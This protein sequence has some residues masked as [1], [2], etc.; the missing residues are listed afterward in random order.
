[1]RF[2][3]RQL[4]REFSRE[5]HIVGI[6]K[7]N[8]LPRRQ[9]NASIASGG[10]SLIGLAD[11]E[12]PNETSCDFCRAICRTIVDYDDLK[13]GPI[14]GEHRADRLLKESFAVEYGNYARDHSGA[15]A[16]PLSGRA[17]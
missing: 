2:E 12:Y 15:P 3:R 5:P 11:N 7:S 1:M 13:L 16:N 17:S 9:I 14:L 6:Q 10:D 8:K 4:S